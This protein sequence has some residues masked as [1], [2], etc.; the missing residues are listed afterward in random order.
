VTSELTLP[1]YEIRPMRPTEIDLALD[2]AAAEGWN[3]GLHD[4]GAFLT[5]DPQGFLLGLLNGE[6][7]ACISAVNYDDSF[8]FLGFYIVRAE[9]QGRGYGLAIWNAAMAHHGSR[10]VG[11]D[12]V[13]AQQHN[14]AKSGFVLAH[15]NIRYQ[16]VAANAGAS[17][18]QAIADL[19]SLPF[20]QVSDFDQ[21]VFPA[22]RDAFLRRWITQPDSHA[23][24]AVTDGDIKGYAVTRKCRS[25]HKI[26]PLFARSEGIA[27]D[28]FISLTA[29]IDPGSPIFLDV[30]EL[31]PPA[32]N[33][34]QRHGMKPSFETARM[35]NKGQPTIDLN[36]VFGIT[37]FEL[38]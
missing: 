7:I 9:F 37:T 24:A 16:G 12:G 30:P 15:R 25:G 26:G 10:N 8:G 6:P 19:A 29:R 32:V 11:L 38:G 27:E 2:W 28:L 14:Y 22:K 5:V 3:P 17:P 1:G 35:Y 4:A 23:L 20:D 18:N 31:N 36:K 33:L 13:P 34:A 21:L